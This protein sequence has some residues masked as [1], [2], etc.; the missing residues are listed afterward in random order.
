MRSSRPAC[1]PKAGRREGQLADLFQHEGGHPQE[2]VDVQRLRDDPQELQGRRR[3]PEEL[4]VRPLPVPTLSRRSSR[5]SAR[6]G[7]RGCTWPVGERSMLDAF[8]SAAKPVADQD[9]GVLVP[10]YRFYPSIESF[11]DTAVKRTI[12][13]AGDN[14]GLEHL[15]RPVAPGPLP[16]PL[17]RGDQGE[18]RQPRDPLH[19]GDR[20]RPAG[21]AAADR[22]RASAGWRRRR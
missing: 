8:Q 9:V 19:R 13:Q 10:L 12:D 21:P 7:R 15:R 6:P 18:R 11:L 5:R 20:R 17:R 16:D 1:S 14:A 22:G 2:P 3:L 4:P